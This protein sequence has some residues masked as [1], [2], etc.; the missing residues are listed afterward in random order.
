MSLRSHWLG[1]V[2]ERKNEFKT[3]IVTTGKYTV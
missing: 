2:N 3:K 1:T